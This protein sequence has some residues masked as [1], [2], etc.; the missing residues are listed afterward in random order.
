MESYELKFSTEA[1]KT[2]K[3]LNEIKKYFHSLDKKISLEELSNSFKLNSIKK[4]L[5]ENLEMGLV[6]SS[7]LIEKDIISLKDD[8]DHMQFRI[9]NIKSKLPSSDSVCSRLSSCDTCTSNP[10]CG[11]CSMTQ[12]CVEG[13]EKGPLNGECSIYDYNKCSGV[14][15]EHLL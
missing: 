8:I 13:N 1:R 3:S 4:K 11:W 6:Q 12:S 5:V 7:N 14:T 10:S 15:P 9:E 2:Q